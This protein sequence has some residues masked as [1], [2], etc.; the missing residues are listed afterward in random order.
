[1][2]CHIR[3]AQLWAMAALALLLRVGVMQCSGAGLH[4]DEAQYWWWSQSLRWGYFSKPPLIAALIAGSTSLFGD[5]LLGVRLW[6]MACWPAS[7]VLMAGLARDVARWQQPGDEPDGSADRAALWT[8][9]LWLTTPLVGLLGLVATTD[10]P[11]VLFWSMALWLAWRAAIGGR[12]WAWPALGIAMGAG[13]LSKYTMAT[14][15]PGLMLWLRGHGRPAAGIW[16]P[17]CLLVTGL[18]LSP[19]LAWN[20]TSDWQPWRH[21]LAS[22]DASSGGVLSGPARASL[23]LG[24]QILVLGPVAVTLGWRLRAALIGGRRLVLDPLPSLVLLSTLPLLL[25]A[26]LQAFRGRVELNWVA[27]MHLALVLVIGLAAARLPQ[28]QRTRWC[29]ALAAQ[30][31]AVLVLALAPA[32]LQRVHPG[33][34]MPPVLDPWARMR[35]WSPAL[36]QLA[37]LVD[38]APGTRLLGTSRAVL[39]HTLYEWRD[40]G[41]RPVGW[42]GEGAPAHHFVADCPW[43]AARTDGS[44]LLIV[45]EGALPPTLASELQ[46][47]EQMGMAAAPRSAS[48]KIEIHLY[49]GAPRPAPSSVPRREICQ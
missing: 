4:V 20:L 11:L 2:S 12:R 8:A 17:I 6:T 29:S 48:R 9:G 37:P 38:V 13:L 23:M 44:P 16:L 18:V 45:S 41:L 40:R 30:A 49:R 10:G 1:M 34:W 22:S 32:A 36:G 28:D 25:L 47:L 31:L 33:W 35:G 3:W 19:H 43:A 24:G 15:L 14:L 42:V 21:V 39:A 26:L 27:P 7:A 46:N 5:S